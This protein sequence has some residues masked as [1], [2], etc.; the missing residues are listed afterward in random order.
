M[1]GQCSC[2]PTSC[3]FRFCPYRATLY[4]CHCLVFHANQGIV[5]QHSFNMSDSFE[6][7]TFLAGASK[8]VELHQLLKQCVQEVW[9]DGSTWIFQFCSQRVLESKQTCSDKSNW[10]EDQDLGLIVRMITYRALLVVS[11]PQ[12][13]YDF[14][15]DCCWCTSDWWQGSQQWQWSLWFQS[16]CCKTNHVFVRV[17]SRLSLFRG[18]PL[19]F[20]YQERVDLHRFHQ[21]TFWSRLRMW[22]M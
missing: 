15:M 19:T 2:Q 5:P 12:Q 21:E 13:M 1:S 14:H 9:D 4:K 8:R 7:R 18:N 22:N 6:R 10:K 16:C 20:G 11:G 3:K 17:I